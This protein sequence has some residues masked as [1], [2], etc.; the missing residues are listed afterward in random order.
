MRADQI[1]SRYKAWGGVRNLSKKFVAGEVTLKE[2]SKNVSVSTETV[3]NDFKEVLGVNGY[4]KIM[5]KVRAARR[6]SRFPFWFELR[7]KTNV[8]T[9]LS[10]RFSIDVNEVLTLKG[11]LIKEAPHIQDIFLGK[12]GITRARTKSG[13]KVCVRNVY[14][15]KELK[16]YNIEFIRIK[17]SPKK[18]NKFDFFIFRVNNLEE[19]I[20]Y[21]FNSHELSGLFS[22]VILPH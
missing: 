17:L 4:G 20:Y 11:D 8:I 15:R 5:E 3:R 13:K 19:Y 10:G 2:I 9:S 16:E 21:I 1:K 7:V 18:T 14:V 22:L 6:S 12:N